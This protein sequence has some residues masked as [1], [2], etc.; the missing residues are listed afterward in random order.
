MLGR[1]GMRK[2]RRRIKYYLIRL[3][4]QKSGIHSVALG[5]SLGF[6][7]NLFPTFGLG[8]IISVAISN[9]L[10]G[11]AIS[12]LLGATAGSWAW[13]FLF[14]LNYTVGEWIT[15]R[16]VFVENI[17]DEDIDDVADQVSGM[18]LNFVVGTAV[19]TLIFGVVLYV[20]AFYTFGRYRGRML[21]YIKSVKP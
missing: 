17:V 11:N 6:L 15:E 9:L 16:E 20:L 21:K 14:V 1:N 4:R 10:R 13:P 7:P 19:N 3:L 5:F 2:W 8:P 18:G 12:A